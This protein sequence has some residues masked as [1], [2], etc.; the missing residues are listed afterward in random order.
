MGVESESVAKTLQFEGIRSKGIEPIVFDREDVNDFAKVV[1]RSKEILRDLNRP[2]SGVV[3][4]LLDDP[5]AASTSL[6]K[7]GIKSIDAGY[8]S[9]VK[10]FLRAVEA[11]TDVMLEQNSQGGR[12]VMLYPSNFDEKNN[13]VKSIVGRMLEQTAYELKHSFHSSYRN[14]SISTVASTVNVDTKISSSNLY[15]QQLWAMDQE[16]D[17]A[18]VNEKGYKLAPDIESTLYAL[19]HSLLSPT[20]KSEYNKE[21]NLINLR[22]TM[23]NMTN[24]KAVS[25]I[26][27]ISLMV[28]HVVLFFAG[29]EHG[30]VKVPGILHSILTEEFTLR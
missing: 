30:N 9:Y 16:V 28:F 2:L 18:T 20:P 15:P 14:L 7:L 17:D 19:Q 21:K 24:K 10:P 13:G 23:H 8:R 22:D 25:F 29:D 3:V 12:V 26:D 4:N 6:E 11:C 1:Y 27:R 5:K